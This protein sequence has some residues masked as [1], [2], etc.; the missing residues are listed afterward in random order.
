MNLQKQ[1]SL[2][3]CALGFMLLAFS[4]RLFGDKEVRQRSRYSDSDKDWMTQKSPLGY[5]PKFTVR[6][7]GLS[8]LLLNLY[9]GLF[10]WG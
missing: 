5:F 6:F 4:V 1:E 3:L 10:S 7:W 8:S 9:L 2:R